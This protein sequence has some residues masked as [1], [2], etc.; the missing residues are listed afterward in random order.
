[1]SRGS[2][3]LSIVQRLRSELGRAENVNVGVD[4]LPSLKTTINDVYESLYDDYDWPHLRKVFPRITLQAG[5]QYYDT[6]VDLNFERIEKIEVWYSGLPHPLIR[7]IGFQEYAYFDTSPGGVGVRSEPALRWDL[8]W[9]G[10]KEQ[11]EIWPIP[12]SNGQALQIIGFIKWQP[13]VN[14]SDVCLIDD[15][16][17]SLFCAAEL[18][19]RQNSK[20]AQ[21]KL[22]RAKQRF[23]VIKGRMRGAARMHRMGAGEPYPR[24]TSRAIVR[25]R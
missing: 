18:L 6:P 16:L 17:V 20:D 7:G 2:Q 14:D 11:M 19:A 1:M 12:T 9:T 22:D 24:E 21:A 13:L 5:L 23:R 3:F 25:V 8:R 10:S 4:D 15:K